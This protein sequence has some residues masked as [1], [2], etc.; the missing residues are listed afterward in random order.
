MKKF[1]M[2]SFSADESRISAII[3]GFFITLIISMQQYILS[4]T[5]DEN[6]KHLLITFV[7]VIGGVHVS[8]QVKEYITI[9]FRRNGKDSSPEE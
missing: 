9:E 2:Q 5:I 1:L 7:Y 8:N 3:L 6:A 4:G